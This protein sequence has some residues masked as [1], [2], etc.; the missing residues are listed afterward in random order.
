MRDGRRLVTHWLFLLPTHLGGPT[1]FDIVVSAVG[2]GI[3]HPFRTGGK[4]YGTIS[5]NSKFLAAIIAGNTGSPIRMKNAAENKTID[6]SDEF[7]WPFFYAR[8]GFPSAE[9]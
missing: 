8:G 2:L 5:F 1:E 9:N 3:N 4:H 6:N 7:F